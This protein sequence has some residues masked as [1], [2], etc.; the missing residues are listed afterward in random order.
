MTSLRRSSLYLS[1]LAIFSTGLVT[2]AGVVAGAAVAK[3]TTASILSA[4][5]K[6]L[7]KEVSVHVKVSSLSGKVASSVVADIG[8][9]SGTETFKEGKESFTITVTPKYAYLSGSTTGLTK[10]MGLTSAEQKKVG[11]S[12]ISMKEGSTPYTTFKENLTTGALTKLLPEAKG[13]TLLKKRDKATNGYDLSWVTAASSDSPKTTTVMTISSG[14]KSLPIKELVST[15]DG[16]SETTFTRWGESVEV[17]V[18]TSTIPYDTV[19]PASS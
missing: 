4:T 8:K 10:I 6:V 11:T 14:K 5:S 18:P 17:V 2:S 3:P 9:T 15:S 7:D 16:T 13:T 12:A 19:F 1:V